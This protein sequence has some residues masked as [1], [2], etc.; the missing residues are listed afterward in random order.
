MSFFVFGLVVWMLA[1]GYTGYHKR[2]G[3]FLLVVAVGLALNALW[4]FLW[5]DANPFSYYALTAQL[6]AL[7]YALGALGLGWFIG[8]MAGKFRESKV[9]PK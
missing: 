2:F 6:G 7:S 8:R 3:L 4:M 9:S 5:L 1:C